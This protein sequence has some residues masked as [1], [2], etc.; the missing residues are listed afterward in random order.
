MFRIF[1]TSIDIIK[2]KEFIT[3]QLFVNNM[4]IILLKYAFT[5]LLFQKIMFKIIF[6]INEKNYLKMI[7]I[8]K[9]KNKC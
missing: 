5:F 7:V 1:I 2:V 4:L 6:F 3:Y 9:L 8:M